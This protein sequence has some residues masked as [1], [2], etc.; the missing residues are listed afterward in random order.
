MLSVPDSLGYER[1]PT[2]RRLV[3]AARSAAARGDLGRA[4]DLLRD[5]SADDPDGGARSDVV[6]MALARGHY[7]VAASAARQLVALRPNDGIAWARLAN[8]LWRGQEYD[9]ARVAADRALAIAPDHWLVQQNVG[10]LEYFVGDP[11]M[12]VAHLE[13][14]LSLAPGE[15]ASVR[16]WIRNDLAH[17]VLKSGD[18]RRGLELYEARWDVVPTSP[19]WGCGLPLWG[20][21]RRAGERMLLHA[22]QG[23]GDTIQFV[24]FVCDI[25]RKGVF[26][27]V[28]LAVPKPLIRLLEGQ[29]GV[30][31]VVD[32]ELVADLVVASRTCHCHAP[33]ITAFSRLGYDYEDLA[34]SA[35]YLRRE[36]NSPR[37]LRGPGT[38]LAVGVVWAASVG[39]ERSRQRSVSPLDLLPLAEVPGVRLWSLQ[40]AP[41]AHEAVDTGADAVIG[42]ATLAT[43]DF[44][45]T[46]G[47]VQALDAVVTVD[48]AMVHLCGALGKRCFM[49]NPV[50]SCWRWCQ[51]AGPWYQSVELFDQ[52]R[53]LLWDGAILGIKDRLA[54]MAE[55]V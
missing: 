14:A 28:V 17:A 49:L 12:A 36:A 10:L 46:A 18:L 8:A 33:L 29:C 37:Q 48:T 47:I 5:A 42:D 22:E 44:Q 19:A 26:G 34:P 25:K 30:D 7:R 6:E 43:M 40:M 51:G 15:P 21:E 9:D 2:S 32:H 52:G 27:R 13:F 39:H 11:G 23:Y 53:D 24:Q 31:N 35:P 55:R 4:V 16:N 54:E 1:E 41:Y 45:D 50:A 38:R 3:E 20:G